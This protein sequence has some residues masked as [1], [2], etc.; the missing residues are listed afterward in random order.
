MEMGERVLMKQT[1]KKVLL[2][3]LV[4]LLLTIIVIVIDNL[5]GIPIMQYNYPLGVLVFLFIGVSVTALTI[6]LLWLYALAKIWEV[7]K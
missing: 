2:S 6:V 1:V 3:I 5:N 4:T 7:K